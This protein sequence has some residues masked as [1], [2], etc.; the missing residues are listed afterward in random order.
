MSKQD[1]KL[2]KVKASALRPPRHGARPRDTVVEDVRASLARHGQLQPI[3]ARA[4]GEVIVGDQRRRSLGKDAVVD[5]L[6]M[7]VDQVTALEMRLSEECA[8]TEQSA[9]ER[10]E[11]VATLARLLAGSGQPLSAKALAARIGSTPRTVERYLRLASLPRPVKT[12]LNKGQMSYRDAEALADSSGLT[13]A[14]KSAIARKFV[15]G[16]APGGTSARDVVRFVEQAP[17][18]VRERFVSDTRTTYREAERAAKRNQTKEYRQWLSEQTAMRASVFFGKVADRLDGWT[19]VLVQLGDLAAFVPAS[20]KTHLIKALR[21]LTEA[22]QRALVAVE[23]A[24]DESSEAQ[25]L[26]ALARAEDALAATGP[27]LLVD[28]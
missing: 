5:V 19:P 22:S 21:R 15:S 18:K 2:S 3:I 9:A 8:K 27:G 26:K 14:E 7:D 28:P 1:V 17:P 13:P 20:Q 4:D 25:G 11:M 24:G 12:M 10:A 16:A 23:R 6:F